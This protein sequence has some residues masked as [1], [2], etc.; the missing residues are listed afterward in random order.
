MKWSVVI[1]TFRPFILITVII[2]IKWI[3]ENGLVWNSWKDT[4]N[5]KRH[6][7][8]TQ[9]FG[10]LK[11]FVNIT[12]AMRIIIKNLQPKQIMLKSNFIDFK[13]M[14]KNKINKTNFFFVKLNKYCHNSLD[15]SLDIH[16]LVVINFQGI[17]KESTDDNWKRT[18]YFCIK[19]LY[20][21][22]SVF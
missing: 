4:N 5:D 2:S 3:I 8:K 6:V 17:V 15:W 18:S 19:Q 13:I 7:K 9:V 12:T 20:L 14:L 10:V 11:I 21:V 22:I 16:F 1:Y